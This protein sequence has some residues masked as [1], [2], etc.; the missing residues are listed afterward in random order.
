MAIFAIVHTVY[1]KNIFLYVSLLLLA[2]SVTAMPS[3]RFAIAENTIK[4]IKIIEVFDGRN[5]GTASLTGKGENYITNLKVT[6]KFKNY[7]PYEIYLE[8][9]YSPYIETFD[10]GA[11]DKLLFCSSQT[12]GSGGYG[13]YRIYSIKKTSYKLLYDD[14]TNSKNSGF[15]AV[16]K[17]NGFMEITNLSYKHTLDVYLNYIDTE[18]YNLIFAPDG[19]VTGE[20][21]YV[22]EISFVAPALNSANGL[23]TLSTYRPVS[24][25][26]E[27]NRLGYIVQT[28]NF[29]GY[30]FYPAFT[31]FSITF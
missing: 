9:G 30:T 27:V 18:F 31:E 12:G 16:F 3:K 15:S 1:M 2:V 23:Y 29:D 22:K 25:I 21:P 14:K 5:S 10:F 7:N 20:Q 28:L 17:P 13:N 26:A 11:E 4:P 6:I 19:T 8:D 24:A